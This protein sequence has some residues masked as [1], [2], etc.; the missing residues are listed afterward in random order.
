MLSGSPSKDGTVKVSLSV[1]VIAL[2]ADRLSLLADP[3]RVRLLMLLEHGESTG[4]H[5]ADEMDT[6]PQNVSYHLA[7]LHRAGIVS[8]RREGTFV[9]YAIADYSICRVLEQVLASVT[10]HVGELADTLKLAA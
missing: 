10:S 4:Q 2:V 5:L 9:Y 6:T 7:L 1:A 8:R 3:N